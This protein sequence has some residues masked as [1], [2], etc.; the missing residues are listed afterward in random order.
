MLADNLLQIFTTFTLKKGLADQT[1]FEFKL[2]RAASGF[3]CQRQPQMLLCYRS[4]TSPEHDADGETLLAEEAP[5]SLD[6][7]VRWTQ[8]QL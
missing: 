2:H 7:R 4:A 3:C 5:N 6:L 1:A 8:I